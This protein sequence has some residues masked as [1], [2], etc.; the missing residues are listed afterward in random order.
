MKFIGPTFLYHAEIGAKMFAAGDEHPG[1][2]WSD[3]P[4]ERMPECDPR[5][6]QIAA[7]RDENQ[8][9]K[10]ENARLEDENRRLRARRGSDDE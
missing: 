4:F 9:V 5:D 7:L 2:G 8:K 6:A 1:E 10:A 3:E